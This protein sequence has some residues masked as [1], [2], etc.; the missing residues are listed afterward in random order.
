MTPIT[1]HIAA[2]PD[3]ELN[4][5]ADRQCNYQLYN[6]A[7]ANQGLVVYI[8]GFGADAGAYSEKFCQAIASEYQL[9]TM[10]V[11]Y[12]CAK[13]RPNSGAEFSFT[14]A[15]LD[16]LQT[17]TQTQQTSYS[18]AQLQTLLHDNPRLPSQP[19]ELHATLT[20]PN[21]HYQN[22][23]VMAALDILNSIAHAI[24]QH[25]V[26]QNNI[27]LIGSSYGGYLANL[28]TKFRPGLIR[29]VF[30]NSSSAHANLS[31]I[32]GKEIGEPEFK[33]D[34]RQI[35]INSHL[36]SPWTLSAEQPNTFNASRA[37]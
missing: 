9:A 29:A 4:A 17:I 25:G 18:L 37:Q 20:P 6:A 31:Y 7:Q 19:I 1:E 34:F 2:C 26:N 15:D 11:D 16:T 5:F 33:V 10:Q 27:I 8:P 24:M 35:I 28:A 32:I 23:G 12:F 13:V 30:D 21:G 3:F 14:G 36:I 22:F